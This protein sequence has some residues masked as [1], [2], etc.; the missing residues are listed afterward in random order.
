M[1]IS[2]LA[3]GDELLIIFSQRLKES[4]RNSDTL[5]RVGGDEFLLLAQNIT[6]MNDMDSILQR[7]I[8]SNSKPI[9]RY[10]ESEAGRRLQHNDDM[11]KYRGELRK[12]N[13]AYKG[14]LG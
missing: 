5:T 9:P 7:I 12:V 4:I 6:S 10:D 8:K 14:H 11:V 1:K 13:L 2:L 3:I